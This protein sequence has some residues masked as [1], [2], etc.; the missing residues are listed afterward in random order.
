MEL[1]IA[2]RRVTVC[3]GAVNPVGIASADSEQQMC[4]KKASYG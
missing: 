2:S 3:F 4:L 1:E